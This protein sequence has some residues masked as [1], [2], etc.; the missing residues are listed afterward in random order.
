MNIAIIFAGG[1]GQRL[2]SGQDS[3]PKQFLK[4]MGKPIVIYTLEKFD[5]CTDIDHLTPVYLKESDAY[6]R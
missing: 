1:T 3:T 6:Y 5:E 4:I 2:K